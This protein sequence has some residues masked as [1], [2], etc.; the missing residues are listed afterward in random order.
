LSVHSL[1][2]RSERIRLPNVGESASIASHLMFTSA[3]NH[4]FARDFAKGDCNSD[5]FLSSPGQV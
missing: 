3:A 1:R 2:A 4:E 5:P